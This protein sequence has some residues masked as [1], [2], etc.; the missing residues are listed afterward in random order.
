MKSFSIKSHML[1]MI[2][3]VDISLISSTSI[4]IS[5]ALLLLFCGI[6]FGWGLAVDFLPV[7]VLNNWF[8]IKYNNVATMKSLPNNHI[9]VKGIPI[10]K[11]DV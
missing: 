5:S 6:V 4:L 3:S 9:E 1:S 2:I 7:L 11:Q 10:S 8:L